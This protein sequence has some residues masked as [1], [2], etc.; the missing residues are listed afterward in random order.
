MDGLH[1]GSWATTERS[2]VT[3]RGYRRFRCRSWGC[4]FNER[5]GSLFTRLQYPP[6]VVC[7]VVLWR[8]R[9]KLGLRDWAEMVLERGV[10][11]THEAVREWEAELA[12]V[13]SETP[14]KHR[15]DKGRVSV[16]RE[17]RTLRRRFMFARPAVD[18]YGAR[19]PAGDQ[20]FAPSS[21]LS[22][23]DIHIPL[24]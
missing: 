17:S 5:T 23:G 24:D 2:D 4:S 15:R 20:R 7:L 12:P 8:A 14:R 6:G 1:C 13:L 11:F 21:T 18:A 22:G 16:G 9:Y 3:A 10:I 19:R